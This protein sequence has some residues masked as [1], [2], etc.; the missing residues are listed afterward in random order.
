[1]SR[2]RALAALAGLLCAPA[3]AH[4]AVLA[5]AQ[6]GAA[7]AYGEYE[8]KA[9]FLYNFVRFVEWPQEAFAGAGE[10]LRVCVLGRD[11]FGETLDRALGGKT[12]QGRAL[13]VLR[14]GGMGEAR[15]CHVLFV[16]DPEGR[17]PGSLLVVLG[18]AA[19]LTIG[20]APGFARAG[21]TI[22]FVIEESR[23]RFEINAGAAER[24][25]L[26]I[27]S[28]LLGLARSVGGGGD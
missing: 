23:V 8:V 3:G 6:Q 26:R 1:M 27:S 12:V 4:E 9:A 13:E 11:P 10:P 14:V 7:A 25:H 19:V 22:Q 21:G 15:G 28:K 2:L 17:D 16:G 20:E 5:A 24:A 18:D